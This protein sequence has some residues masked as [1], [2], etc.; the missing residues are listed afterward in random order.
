MEFTLYFRNVNQSDP[1]VQ[2]EMREFVAAM[3]SLPQIQQPP[4]FCWVNDLHA[5]MTGEASEEMDED[6]ARQAATL[7]AAIRGNNRTFTEQLDMVLNIPL[8]RDVYGGD[9]VRDEAGEIID[10]R[11][12]LYVRH[13]DLKNI[14]QQT[15]LLLDQ[16]ALTAQFQPSTYDPTEDAD[17]SFFAF[18]EMFYYF[19]LV[20]FG[21][22]R[23]RQKKT[24]L[25]SV[26]I[27]YHST[28]LQCMSLY[29]PL[30]LASLLSTLL[31][32]S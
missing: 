8:I 3:S 29:S 7:A 13:I 25:T 21:S 23:A 30:S 16:R 5:F 20:S 10:S 31:E 9:I 32:S 14:S 22:L 12:Y 11:C 17:L 2:A 19:E 27:S 4:D 24:S 6:Q 15:Q 26:T 1:I 18:D 28:L